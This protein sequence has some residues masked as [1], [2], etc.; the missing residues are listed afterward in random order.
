M[1]DE[2]PELG[3]ILTTDPP[4]RERG[5]HCGVTKSGLWGEVALPMVPVMKIDQQMH[6][7][8]QHIAI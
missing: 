5:R 7:V 3:L 2:C 6:G 4:K 1:W 8:V